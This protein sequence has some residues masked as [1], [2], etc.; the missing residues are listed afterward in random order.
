MCS[1]DLS[2]ETSEGHPEH[3]LN[4]L[5][6]GKTYA[7][8]ETKVPAGYTLADTVFFTINNKGTAIEKT[9][10][11]N[12]H[13][14]TFNMSAD[15][16]VTS[17]SFASRQVLGATLICRNNATNQATKVGLDTTGYVTLTKKQIPTAGS[18]SLDIN[19]NYSDG[20]SEVIATTE[21]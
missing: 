2:W 15:G 18:Y 8:V 1:S 9:W 14:V 13:A 3:Q 6:A 21:G 17:V 12:G 5:A 10:T 19:V 16:T 20:T 7:L 4:D 11:G